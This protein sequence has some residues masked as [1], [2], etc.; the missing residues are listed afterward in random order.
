MRCPT[1]D[2][3][4]GKP[5]NPPLVMNFQYTLEEKK[6]SLGEKLLEEKLSAA[7]IANHRRM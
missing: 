6:A 2:A 1:N 3:A 7:A 4:R 5:I